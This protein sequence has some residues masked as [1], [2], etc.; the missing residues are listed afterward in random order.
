MII[1]DYNI[2]IAIVLGLV[3]VGLFYIGIK[4]VLKDKRY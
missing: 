2:L 1:V 3:S 4:M